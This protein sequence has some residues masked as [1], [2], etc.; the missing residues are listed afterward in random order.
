[1]NALLAFSNID[2]A[3]QTI[4]ALPADIFLRGHFHYFFPARFCR[5]LIRMVS[6]RPCCSFP[7]YVTNFTVDASF[8]VISVCVYL[9]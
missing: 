8:G 1:M 6:M 9:G 3:Q 2:T 4:V 5:S 7:L